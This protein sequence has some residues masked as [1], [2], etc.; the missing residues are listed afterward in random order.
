MLKLFK[1]N[2]KNSSKYLKIFLDKRKSIQ[3]TQISNV[4]RIIKNV[5]KNGDKAV[6]N[7]EKKFSKIKSNSNKI[8]FSTK[9]I[10]KLSKK[11]N[12]KIRRSIDLAF[13]R[14]K[15][16]HSK[17][18]FLPFTLKDKYNNKLSYKYSS[19]ENV[20][21]YVPGGTA[22]YPSTVLMNCIPAIVAGVKNIYLATPSLDSNINPAVIYAAKKCGVKKFIKQVALILSQH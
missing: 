19:I 4:T 15:K 18:K 11:T 1:F 17:Q 3:K 7:Y 21:V 12:L 14:I 2:N 8:I 20:G 16:F 5:K 9:E 10:N 13:N 22:S 6:I